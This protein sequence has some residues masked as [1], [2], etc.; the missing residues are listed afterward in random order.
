[1]KRFR[2]LATLC[3]TA[4]AI[5]LSAPAAVADDKGTVPQSSIIKTT[6][7]TV[8]YENMFVGASKSE[9]I[10]IHNI[11]DKIAV[12]SPSIDFGDEVDEYIDYELLICEV[13]NKCY[14]SN[15]NV[16]VQIPKGGTL[17][18][19]LAITL[20]KEIKN[21]DQLGDVAVRGSLV[22]NGQALADDGGIE[23][24][25]PED[26]EKKDIGVLAST[27]VS[28]LVLIIAISAFSLIVAGC[29]FVLSAR[30][31]KHEEQ[32]Q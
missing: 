16:F 17:D 27:G 13:A 18:V 22:I 20:K 25:I 23:E 4:F 29:F 31:R 30:K 8:Y 5:A 32:V 19:E 12:I 10:T 28:N 15:P 3:V 14:K 6:P 2:A 7:D 26:G 11:S 21:S 9:T 24:I 1:M